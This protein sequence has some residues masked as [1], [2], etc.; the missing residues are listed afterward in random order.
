ME[1][2]RRYCWHVSLVSQKPC[3]TGVFS[4]WSNIGNHIVPAAIQLKPTGQYSPAIQDIYAVSAITASVF[5]QIQYLCSRQNEV[6][7]D[8]ANQPPATNF[9]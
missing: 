5:A 7:K 8:P 6:P 1:P 4:E 2:V 3:G 9:P